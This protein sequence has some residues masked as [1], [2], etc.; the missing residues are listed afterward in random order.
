M[1]NWFIK[2]RYVEIEPGT[3]PVD[4][5]AVREQKIRTAIATLGEKWVLRDTR[6]QQIEQLKA[7][8]WDLV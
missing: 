7:E 2:E 1:R 8:G 4:A 3:L 6:K 5:N